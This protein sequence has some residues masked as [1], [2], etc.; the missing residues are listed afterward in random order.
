MALFEGKSKIHRKTRTDELP[1]FAARFGILLSSHFICNT[2]TC[3]TEIAGKSLPAALHCESI[4]ICDSRQ[5]VLI[6]CE[7]TRR[8]R[9]PF[10][11]DLV[12]KFPISYS[13][14]LAFLGTFALACLTGFFLLLP[15]VK[16]SDP[17]LFPETNPAERVRRKGSRHCCTEYASH[18][19]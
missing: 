10:Y 9:L 13:L 6:F 15:V 3:V 7:Y 4:K 2:A 17:K 12:F 11:F 14:F 5:C 18:S 16:K 19:F 1:V 8:A